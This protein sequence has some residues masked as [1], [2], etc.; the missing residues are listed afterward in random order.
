MRVDARRIHLR[1]LGDCVVGSIDPTTGDTIA[2]CPPADT[3]GQLTAI[4]GQLATMQYN[5]LPNQPAAQTAT[6]Q[7]ILGMPLATAATV[8]GLALLA[9]LV[10]PNLV[11]G[12]RR[13]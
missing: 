4:A 13:R 6:P 2:N 12:G 7:T 8:G 5:Q 9:L 3:T 10:L 1:G 11:G